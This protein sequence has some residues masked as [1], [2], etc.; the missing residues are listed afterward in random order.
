LSLKL[1]P[2]RL[3]TSAWYEAVDHGG[4]DGGVAEHFAPAAVG[5]VRGD[6]HG[7][8]PMRL[9]ILREL[10][11]SAVLEYAKWHIERNTT[12]PDP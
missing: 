7:V 2:L 6:D 9:L 5:L 8:D 10:C 11:E 4:G 3:T 12:A 1:S